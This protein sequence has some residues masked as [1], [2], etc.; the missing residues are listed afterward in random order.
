MHI[1]LLAGGPSNEH[2]VSVRS[3]Q[4]VAKAFNELGHTYKVI[5]PGELDFNL[6]NHLEGVDL[7]FPALHGAGGE[8]GTLQKILEDVGVK[9]VGS[10]SSASEICFDKWQYKELLLTNE[11]PASNGKLV[12]PENQND[13]WF[14]RPYVLKPIEGGS[15]LDTQ[16]VRSPNDQT[17]A[18]AADL[19]EKYSK[20]LLEPI[21]EG[22]EITVGILG[23]Q[24]LP[25]IEIVPPE[26]REFDYENKYNGATQE[27][28]PP[29][30]VGEDIQDQAKELAL[31]IHQLCGCRHMSRTDMIIDSSG[32]LHV[33]ETNTIP[34]MTDQ[35]LLPKMANEAGMPMKDFVSKLIDLAVA[36]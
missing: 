2:D 24:A 1:L 28:C 18:E 15:S 29:Q 26:G 35:S 9:F 32:N 33:L 7:V 14:S 36:S 16:I 12:T 13:Q 27:L 31:K 25:V 3:G 5:D 20:M 4:A 10:G 23:D 21:I 17:K 22:T 19:L 8:D 6:M 11:L 30:N 34:G